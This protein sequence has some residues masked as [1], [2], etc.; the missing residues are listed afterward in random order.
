MNNYSIK[1]LLFSVFI[2][3]AGGFPVY[4]G[5]GRFNIES[6]SS[7]GFTDANGVYVQSW[8]FKKDLYVA[9]VGEKAE[10]RI[11]NPRPGDK[12][13]TTTG[14]SNDN[15]QIFGQCFATKAGQIL[16]YVHSIDNNDDSSQYILYFYDKPTPIPTK[17]I[18]SP[19]PT[20]QVVVSDIPPNKQIEQQI[21]PTMSESI[22]PIQVT[23]SKDSQGKADTNIIQLILE[24]INGVFSKIFRK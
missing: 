6:F 3:I 15:G 4:A 9:S 10:F 21:S 7:P 5:G 13:I 12:C 11:Q 8:I 16:V 23:N 2:L 24:Y 18:F 1:V 14:T 17:K 22:T 20:V 19:T